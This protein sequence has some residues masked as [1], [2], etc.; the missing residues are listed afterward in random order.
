M[1]SPNLTVLNKLRISILGRCR[2]EIE[3]VTS[4]Y[5]AAANMY[6][7]NV[8]RVTSKLYK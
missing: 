5:P 4:M 1:E 7:D 3:T 2:E 8:N 6:Q